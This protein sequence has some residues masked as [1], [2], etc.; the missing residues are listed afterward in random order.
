MKNTNNTNLDILDLLTGKVYDF[1]D[2]AG[3]S[4]FK[5]VL[6]R[7]KANFLRNPYMDIGALLTELIAESEITILFPVNYISNLN[8]NPE[9]LTTKQAKVP[10][11]I[12]EATH[13]DYYNHM[14]A[15]ERISPFPMAFEHSRILGSHNAIVFEDCL[16]IGSTETYITLAPKFKEHHRRLLLPITGNTHYLRELVRYHIDEEDV[17]IYSLPTVETVSSNMC[18]GDVTSLAE[19]NYTQD[20]RVVNYIQTSADKQMWKF[21]DGT[22]SNKVLTETLKYGFLP[23]F[24]AEAIKNEP[25]NLVLRFNQDIDLYNVLSCMMN[26]SHGIMLADLYSHR[27]TEESF[28]YFI[29]VHKYFEEYMRKTLRPDDL[30]AFIKARDNFHA[31]QDLPYLSRTATLLEEFPDYLQYT[32]YLFY[33]YSLMLA[34]CTGTYLTSNGRR[35]LT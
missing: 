22:Y 34:S 25:D 3:E 23:V 5:L 10:V 11:C 6:S 26:K 29:W 18:L 8:N 27:T 17:S 9:W 1:S 4:D 16:I 35:S 19:A 28:N 21:I 15:E 13:S 33:L 32:D 12:T 14:A 7:N 2:S 30:K 31:T 20:L 24:T